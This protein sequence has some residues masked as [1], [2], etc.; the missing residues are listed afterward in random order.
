MSKVGIIG[1]KDSILGFLALGIDIFPAY[2]AEEVK[3]TIHKLA[4]KDYAIIYITEQASLMA[5]ESIAKYKD[6]ELPAI[7]VIPGVGGSMGLGMNEVRESAKR[8][9]GADILFSE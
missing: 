6:F 5:K 2:N 9:I 4:E 3:K 1:D 7:I 8:A